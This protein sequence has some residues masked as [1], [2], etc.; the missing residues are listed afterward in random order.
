MYLQVI[1]FALAFA[2][3]ASNYALTIQSSDGE[4][5]DCFD[6]MK[7][8]AFDNPL[9]KNHRFQE[10]PSEIPKA[11]ET[12]QKRKKQT[13][14]AR[15]SS[16]K[17]PP[18]TVPI[19][20]NN[21]TV[22]HKTQPDTTKHPGH[23]YAIMTTTQT[24]PKLYGTKAI[25]NV[26]DPNIENG[27]KE[28]SISQI[29]IAS[30]QYKSGDLNT[31]EI[32]WQVLPKLYKDN[33]PRLF[34]FWTGNAYKTGCYNVRCPGFIQTSSSIVIGGPISSVSSLGGRQFE[35]TIHVWKDRQYGNWWL[36]LGPNNELVGYWPAEIF[37]TLADHAEVA[38]W[39]GEI[40][41]SRPF[42]RHTMTQM[43]SGRFPDEGFGRSSY[44]RNLQTVDIN[45]SLQRVQDVKSITT[46][47]ESYSVKDLYT[48]EWKT[49][50]FYGGPGFR[51]SHSGAVPSTYSSAASF[52]FFMFLIV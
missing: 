22:N 32:G 33:K 21:A 41:N 30:G 20:S 50:F 9:L 42:D 25:V 34:L 3:A 23:E 17:C 28:M 46:N 26:W 27:A 5:V 4:D 1:L 8:P 36:S 12:T 47:P 24:T 31:V 52:F 40:V 43:G 14:E 16:A 15:T 39:G 13:F 37:T 44:F 38:Q 35:I 18:G 51:P 29:W 2:Q 6:K 48:E 7:Q 10:V 19:R 45:N 49:H 11:I